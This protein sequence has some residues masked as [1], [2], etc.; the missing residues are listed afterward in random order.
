MRLYIGMD[1]GG[2]RTTAVA[3]REDGTLAGSAQGGGLNYL[4]DGLET[5]LGRF[6]QL[7]RELMGNT[8]PE[9]VV[10]SAGLAA[11]DGPANADILRAFRARLPV[12]CTLHLTSDALIALDKC[13]LV[14]VVSRMA[15][16]TTKHMAVR[17]IKHALIG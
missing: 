15:S 17:S 2:T 12:G 1:G 3:V 16:Y 9:D 8:P 11:L 4:Q 10:V 13:N 6:E 7:A 5:C 14:R